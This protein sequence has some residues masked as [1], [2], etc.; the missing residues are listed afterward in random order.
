MIPI[1]FEND[2]DEDVYFFGKNLEEKHKDLFHNISKAEFEEKINALR[3]KTGEL[4]KLEIIVE[5]MKIL[6][7]VGDA[8]T[9]IDLNSARNFSTF[10]YQLA[11]LKDGLF[12][13][14][15]SEKQDDYLMQ[16]VIGIGQ[17]SFQEVVSLMQTVIVHE[18]E[19]QFKNFLPNHLI[20]KQLLLFLG[21]NKSPDSL[22]LQLENG[23]SVYVELT[24]SGIPSS[25]IYD[26]FEMPLYLIRPDDFYWWKLLEED[27]LLYVKY[28]R[29]ADAASFPFK[30]F[31]NQ[32]LNQIEQKDNSLK[33][34]IDL[35]LNG[36]GDSRIAQP[37]VDGLKAQLA[38]GKLKSEN[39]FVVIGRKTFSS[40]IINAFQLKNALNPTFI[41][42][43]TGGKPNHYGEV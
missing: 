13:S 29:C 4:S 36:G 8:H 32:I 23:A 9:T 26:Q 37:L 20:I 10:P 25:S 30:N 16:K 11:Y 19:A 43:A 42:E 18:N 24:N 28:R 41:G 35:R 22:Q 2:W 6:V 27:N 15:I 40:A 34:V 39:I 7:L 1:Q 31:T 12:I 3:S 5:L 38:E 33:V 17:Q 14:E 21:I